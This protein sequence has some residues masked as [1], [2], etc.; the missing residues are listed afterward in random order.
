MGNAIRASHVTATGRVRFAGCWRS[1]ST[2]DECARGPECQGV[3][4]VFNRP[5]SSGCGPC[6]ARCVRS[7]MWACRTRRTASFG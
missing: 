4:R 1:A 3:R 6:D 5:G 7:A 2:A